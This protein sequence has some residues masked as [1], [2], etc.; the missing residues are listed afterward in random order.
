MVKEQ[1]DLL[2]NRTDDSLEHGLKRHPA[3]W[4]FP[5][6]APLVFRPTAVPDSSLDW[7]EAIYI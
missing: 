2:F 1:H 3:P 6:F 4:T 7:R 5:P